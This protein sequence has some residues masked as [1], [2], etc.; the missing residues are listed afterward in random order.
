MFE[1]SV[2]KYGSR[3]ALVYNE[4]SLTYAELGK[5]VNT[6]AYHLAQTGLKPLDKVILQL[7]NIPEFVYTYI[8]L[9][10]IGVIP[11]MA[12]PHHR[13]SLS[14]RTTTCSQFHVSL[15]RYISNIRLWRKSSYFTWDRSGNRIFFD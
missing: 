15:T 4:E 10:K 13:Y 11:V 7:P 1:K 9:V 5:K 8:A 14:R 6:L 3:V 12:L 2:E